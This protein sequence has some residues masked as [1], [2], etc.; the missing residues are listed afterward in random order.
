MH[1]LI[2]TYVK[3]LVLNMSTSAQLA[4]S[5]PAEF[6]PPNSP[7]PL[8][9][10]AYFPYL[11]GSYLAVAASLN[12][13]NVM[14]TFVRMLDSWMKEFGKSSIV[15]FLNVLLFWNEVWPFYI[16]LWWCFAAADIIFFPL[17]YVVI[18]TYFLVKTTSF[19]V[20]MRCRFNDIFSC[21]NNMFSC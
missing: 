21:N 5:M 4:F 11:H 8:S 17:N 15:Q 16:L 7:D 18:T 3:S 2:V 19:L 6:T 20:I 12:G 9:P 10:V 14:A 13:G 1:K